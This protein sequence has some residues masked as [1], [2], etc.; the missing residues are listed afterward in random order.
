MKL[1]IDEERVY[2]IPEDESIEELREKFFKA[3][4]EWKEADKDFRSDDPVVSEGALER[5]L[6]AN[7]KL[8][9]IKRLIKEKTAQN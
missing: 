2:E 1:L 4:E 5:K 7:S 3:V 9:L 8:G 6:G